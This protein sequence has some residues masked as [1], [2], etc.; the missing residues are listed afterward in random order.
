MSK[1]ESLL[2]EEQHKTFQPEDMDF[3]AQEGQRSPTRF[4]AAKSTSRH[5]VIKFSKVTDK[6]ILSAAREKKTEECSNLP[7]NK[8]LHRNLTG[9]ETVA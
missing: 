4:R 8:F 9:Q 3:Q 6:D 5:T 7:D 1:V 2:R